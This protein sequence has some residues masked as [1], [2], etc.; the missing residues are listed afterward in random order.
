M[1]TSSFSDTWPMPLFLATLTLSGL[2]AA[3]L[4]T[5]VWRFL[6]WIALLV[7]V[8]VGLWFALRAKAD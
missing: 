5:G 2:L 1:S 7:P 6:A 4:G 3:L 8:V